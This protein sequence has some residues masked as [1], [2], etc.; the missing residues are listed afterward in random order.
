MQWKYA[1]VLRLTLESPLSLGYREH[2]KSV[3][4]AATLDLGMRHKLHET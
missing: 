4:D 1:L 2:G 3:V